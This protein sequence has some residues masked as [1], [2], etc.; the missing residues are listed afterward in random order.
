MSDTLSWNLQLSIREGRYEELKTL[1]EEMVE[2]TRDEAGTLVY[3]WFVSADH[4]TCHIYERYADDDAVMA[5]VANFGSKF[6]ERF[7]GCLEPTAFYVYGEPSD[8]VRSGLDGLGAAYLG[9]VGG[10]SR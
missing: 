7:M 5:H 4:S 9:P 8:A 1:I 2:S 3:E 6:A 10:F